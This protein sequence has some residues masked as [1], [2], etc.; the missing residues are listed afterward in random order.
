M[1]AICQ[2][3]VTHNLTTENFNYNV[4]KIAICSSIA[5]LSMSVTSDLDY[6]LYHCIDQRYT[7][8]I[9]NIMITSNQIVNPIIYNHITGQ[10]TVSQ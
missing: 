1:T 8:M 9:V 7:M 2:K 5:F 10:D 3:P 6:I 4:D